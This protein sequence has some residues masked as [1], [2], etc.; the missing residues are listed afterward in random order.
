MGLAAEVNLVQRIPPQLYLGQAVC[1]KQILDAHIAMLRESHQLVPRVFMVLVLRTETPDLP[2]RTHRLSADHREV[3]Q[4]ESGTSY[5]IMARLFNNDYRE[6]GLMNNCQLSRQAKHALVSR[7]EA[8]PLLE[9]VEG[10]QHLP[11]IHASET[12]MNGSNRDQLSLWNSEPESLD[13]GFRKIFVQC[14]ADHA[15]SSSSGASE[16]YVGFQLLFQ[17]NAIAKGPAFDERIDR[18]EPFEIE[19]SGCQ[20]IDRLGR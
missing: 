17:I 10:E 11:I 5:R 8:I 1:A 4:E 2:D 20:R 12:R 9:M 19:A 15:V 14:E 6:P 7:K 16:T 3:D 18:G 13:D